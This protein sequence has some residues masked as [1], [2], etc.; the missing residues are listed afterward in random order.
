MYR[1]QSNCGNNLNA[2]QVLR[3]NRTLQLLSLARNLI[4]DE[5]ALALV[6]ILSKFQL[7]DDETKWISMR[8]QQRTKLIEYLVCKRLQKC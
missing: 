7:N 4:R 8:K 6:N 1:S 3:T 2:F 5:G